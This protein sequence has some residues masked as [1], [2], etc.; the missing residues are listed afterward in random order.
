MDRDLS[1]V[2]RGST[3]AVCL[4]LAAM[5]RDG[6]LPIGGGPFVLLPETID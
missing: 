2:R 6:C 3:P 4:G 1:D 5:Y